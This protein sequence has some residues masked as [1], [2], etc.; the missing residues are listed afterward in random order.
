VTDNHPSRL[1]VMIEAE[2]IGVPYVHCGMHPLTPNDMYARLSVHVPHESPCAVCAVNIDRAEGSRRG[3]GYTEGIELPN[4]AA[5]N[6]TAA[7]YVANAV[8]MLA[9]CSESLSRLT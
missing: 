3:R 1:S 7:G 2:G 8:R 6:A 9:G 4:V 5:W